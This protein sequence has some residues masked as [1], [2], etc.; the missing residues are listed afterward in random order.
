MA[1]YVLDENNNKVEAFDKEGVLAVLA[2]A[3]A[4]GSLDNIVA[5][6][7]FVSKLKCCVG[8]TTNNV[9][10]V[11]QSKY[12]E[13]VETGTIRENTYYIITDDT[14][15]EDIDATLQGLT[16]N[17]DNININLDNANREITNINNELP[18]LS[19]ISD[20]IKLIDINT[21]IY[22]YQ[23]EEQPQ[24]DI[25]NYLD[26]KI[27]R[28]DTIGISG[29]L[30]VSFDNNET[31]AEVPFSILWNVSHDFIS[32]NGNEAGTSLIFYSASKLYSL[33]IKIGITDRG[34]IYVNGIQCYNITDNIEE[35]FINVKLYNLNIFYK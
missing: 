7:A 24:I 11:P 32:V 3:I 4:D 27:A 6:S 31:W 26:G 20:A 23:K 1:F 34:E 33:I 8:G 2:Q 19:K 35:N 29:E 21:I 17:V 15:V 25:S 9:A 16:N 13:L 5:D 14:T 18:N 30:F 28:I 10:F 12:N 22:D